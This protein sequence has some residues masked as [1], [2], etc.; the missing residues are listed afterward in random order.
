MNNWQALWHRLTVPRAADDEAARQEHMTKVL[1]LMAALL[2]LALTVSIAVGWAVRAFTFDSLVRVLLIDLAVG[3]GLW[4]AQGRYWRLAAYIL[5]AI[6]VWQAIYSTL[7]FGLEYSENFYFFAILLVGMLQ[8]TKVQWIM[9]PVLLVGYLLAGWLHGDRIADLYAISALTMGS[10]LSGI[11]VVQWLSTSHLERAL[12]HARST[13]AELQGYRDHLEEMVK[14]RTAALAVANEELQHEIGERQRAEEALQK[15]NEELESRV[16][17]RTARLVETN[18]QL[19]QEIAERKQAEEALAHERDLLQAIMDNIPDSIYFKDPQSRFV[20]IN[21]A[22]AR[23]LGLDDPSEAIGRSDRDFFTEDHARDAYRDEQRIVQ[24]GQ[25]LEDKEERI[26]TANKGTRWV[27]TTKVPLFDQ[28]QR[29]VGIAGITRDITERVQVE[30]ALRKSQTLLDSLLNSLPL[31]V[32]SKDLDGHFTFA[33]QNYV[34]TEHCSLDEILGKTDFDLYPPALAQKYRDDDRQVA[35]TEDVLEQVEEHQPLGRPA[36]YVQVIK[37]PLYDQE[38]TVAGTLGIF[39]DVTERQRAEHFLQSLN[40]VA[41]AMEK[42]LTH[43]EIFAAVSQEF[44]ELG[45]ACT[46]LPLDDSKNR[47]VARYLNLDDDALGAAAGLLGYAQTSFSF[48]IESVDLFRTII[49][50]RKTIYIEDTVKVIGQLLP[51]RL[52][53]WAERVVNML[54]FWTAIAAPLIV[55]DQVIGMLTAQ[56]KHLTEEDKPAITALANQ[57]AAAWRKAQLMEDLEKSLEELKRTQSQLIQAQKMEAVGRLAGGVAHDFNN[58]LTIVDLNAQLLKRR[59]HP[60]DPIWEHVQ[61]IQDAGSRASKLT[62]QLLSFSRREIIEPQV[63]DLS[64]TVTELGPMLQRVVGENVA[65]VTT[66]SKNLWPVRVDPS[67]ME[68]VI[69]NLALNARDAMVGG[70]RLSIETANE[71]VD[72]DEAGDEAEIA[73]GKYAVLTV[74]DTG[75]G[76]SDE[77][78]AHLF[79]PFF[80][81]KE[82]GKGTGLGLPTVYG[83]VKQNSG[84]IRVHSEVGWGTTFKIYLPYADSNDVDVAKP[85]RAAPSSSGRGSETILVVEDEP[86]VRALAVRVLESYGYQV[87]SASDGPTALQMSERHEQPIDLLLT[88]VIMPTMNGKELVERL[89]QQQPQM[90]VIFMSGYGEDVIAHHGV[91]DQGIT[92]LSKPFDLDSLIRQVRSA[93]DGS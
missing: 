42:A 35:E 12:A 24:T 21:P 75:I 45:V 18:E 46:I 31:N 16:R 34:E 59:L 20:R 37:T 3:V 70:G 23:T 78:K 25:R 89:W 60:H 69:I 2:F 87:L 36:S 80:T 17:E 26:Q 91:L 63:I 86:G 72:V 27:L 66:L 71:I 28:E 22:Q 73:A 62:A 79:E 50:E 55:G 43:D 68:Q 57:V 61:Q 33:N 44:G 32:Y 65:L 9:L 53:Q 47:L 85:K 7:A 88:D 51:P 67:Q 92:L 13:A 83:I 54:D 77:V 4:L 64:Q 48:P 1:L 41:L 29:V 58:L 56:A 49:W 6:F 82:P 19:E 8:G 76:M 38:G 5:P 30:E 74:A 39:W 14:E 84:H 10:F 52:K 81:T 40:R 15:A 93:L 90:R 11:A